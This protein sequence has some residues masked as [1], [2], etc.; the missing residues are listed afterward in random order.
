MEF[1]KYLPELQ[2]CS[3]YSSV[4]IVVSESEYKSIS[5]AS[6]AESLKVILSNFLCLQFRTHP[7]EDRLPVHSAKI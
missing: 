6:Q 4:A 2:Y 7:A 1:E 5:R 3:S